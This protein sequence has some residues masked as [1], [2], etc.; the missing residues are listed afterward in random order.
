MSRE[1]YSVERV[2]ERVTP[3]EYAIYV[4]V[5][6]SAIFIVPGQVFFLSIDEGMR[7]VRNGFM[8]LL[9]TLTAQSV[10]LVSLCLGF[11]IVL[12]HFL[13]VLRF[14]GG[15]LLV[16]LGVS[17]IY[18]GVKGGKINVGE[19][20]G[21]HYMR[22]FLLTI[23]N[24]PLILWYVTVGSTMLEMGVLALG[25]L[26]YV[27]FSMSLLASPTIITAAI[28]LSVQGGRRLIGMREIRILSIVSGT[29]FILIA[30]TMIV[31]LL[32]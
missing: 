7:G 15:I 5:V 10:L 8:M 13:V 25:N 31:P 3:A 9:G 28:V 19:T 27:L 14:V 20:R 18:R 22:G 1:Y 32:I 12:Q 30:L 26:A 6:C 11:L 21:V 24:P 2:L 16:V 29:A 4:F 23:F 17:A